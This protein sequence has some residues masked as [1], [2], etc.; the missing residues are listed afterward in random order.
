ME[1][2]TP[3]FTR[4]QWEE[5]REFA[6]DPEI[7]ELSFERWQRMALIGEEAFQ[8]GG[9]AVRRRYVD[10]RQLLAWCRDHGRRVDGEAL[11]AFVVRDN[12]AL[13]EKMQ[14]VSFRLDE[15]TW[16]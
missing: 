11:C 4:D 1:M 5:L 10:T 12:P 14:H 2:R 7:R 8:D 6:D 16:S 9:M 15:G 13:L 3:W